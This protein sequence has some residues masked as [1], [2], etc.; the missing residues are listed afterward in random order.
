MVCFDKT[1]TITEEQLFVEGVREVILPT[2]SNTEPQVND[3]MKQ[4]D[5]DYVGSNLIDVFATTHSVSRINGE[6]V[7]H[8]VDVKMLEA[9]EWVR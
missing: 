2:N 1:G 9:T 7:G 8:P 4:M 6:L 5:P 3:L